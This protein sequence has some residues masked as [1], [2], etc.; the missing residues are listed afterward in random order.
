[1][2]E[3][4]YLLIQKDTLDVLGVFSRGESAA[5]PAPAA[6]AGEFFQAFD[7]TTGDEVARVPVD[8]LEVKDTVY[9]ETVITS[10]RVYR[11]NDAGGPLLNPAGV[12][13]VTINTGTGVARATFAAIT[14]ADTP[15]WIRIEGPGL[16]QPLTQTAK[17]AL[18][19]TTFDTAQAP[20]Q[21]ASRYGVI[22]FVKGQQPLYAFVNT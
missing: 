16:D 14:T 4:F 3:K 12:S 9:N 6:V 5:P 13:G 1:M 19:L 22:C 21:A 17:L 20:F 7:E 11:W 18:G 15:L 8:V 10:P 2:S